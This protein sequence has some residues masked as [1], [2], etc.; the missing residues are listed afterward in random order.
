MQEHIHQTKLMLRGVTALKEIH[1]EGKQSGR[2]S[3]R[4]FAQRASTSIRRAGTACKKASSRELT[5]SSTGGLGR[6][7]KGSRS[8]P[9]VPFM[10]PS[11]SS[12]KDSST[13]LPRK[14]S[15]TFGHVAHAVDH[16]AHSAAHAVDH[17][18]H[19]AVHAVDHAAHSAVHAIA[20][21]IHH[22]EVAQTAT[23]PSLG[24]LTTSRAV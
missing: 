23:D 8:R 17:A 1:E 10:R 22:A 19:A 16:A 14:A 21:Q 3:R 9:T 18:A 15:G 7:R 20:H 5:E 2:S 12:R 11:L 13:A 24:D 6:V 4:S